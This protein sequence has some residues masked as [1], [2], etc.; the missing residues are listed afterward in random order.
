M[1][2]PVI[3]SYPEGRDGVKNGLRLLRLAG[4]DVPREYV[5]DK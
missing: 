4:D 1:D 5:S 3:K 2:L